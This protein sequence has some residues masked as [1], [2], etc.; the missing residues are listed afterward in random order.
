MP[1]FLY[2]TSIIKIV[3]MRQTIL[4]IIALLLTVGLGCT[5]KEKADLVITGGVVFTAD[6]LNPRAEAVAV[7]GNRILAAGSD[8]EIGRYIDPQV[9][10]VIDAG[11]RAV[12]RQRKIGQR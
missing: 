10:R 6:S 9:T 2:C 1:I 12:L 7:K 11:G 8:R 3:S 5:K 4:M